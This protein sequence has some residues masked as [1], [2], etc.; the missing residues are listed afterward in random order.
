MFNS[1]FIQI[2]L[3]QIITQDIL[4]IVIANCQV[5]IQARRLDTTHITHI[6]RSAHVLVAPLV[7]GDV[8]GVDTR[9]VIHAAHIHVHVLH[10]IEG[11]DRRLVI[12]AVDVVRDAL[13]ADGREDVDVVVDV[14]VRALVEDGAVVVRRVRRSAVTVAVAVVVH[15]VSDPC[16][17]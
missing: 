15:V 16:G 10:Q 3:D 9:D 14:D 8:N 6:T 17:G 2:S 1:C 11:V 12:D 4:Y 13:H 5:K 7:I